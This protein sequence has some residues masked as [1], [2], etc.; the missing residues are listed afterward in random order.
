MASKVGSICKVQHRTSYD[1]SKGKLV[2]KRVK[3]EYLRINLE[4]LEGTVTVQTKDGTPLL[5]V[6]DVQPSKDPKAQFETVIPK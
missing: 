2:L 1:A 4:Y 5:D 6:W 3:P